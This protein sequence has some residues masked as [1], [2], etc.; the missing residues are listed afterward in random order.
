MPITLCSLV[1]LFL[2]PMK[3]TSVMGPPLPY[4]HIRPGG[5]IPPGG[6]T[7]CFCNH[8]ASL[9]DQMGRLSVSG[10]S[11]PD[12]VRMHCWSVRK[13]IDD[14]M[15]LGDSFPSTYD[16]NVV[17]GTSLPYSDL[18]PGGLIPSGGDTT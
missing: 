9:H 10:G 2:A 7:T 13:Y 3:A 12:I 8:N 18:R 17:Y 5:L 16:S 1:S 6:D 11:P 14:I 15:Q 4:G